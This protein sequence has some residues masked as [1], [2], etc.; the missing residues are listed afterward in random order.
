MPKS[1][2]VYA[3]LLCRVV[4][5]AHRIEHLVHELRQLDVNRALP[6]CNPVL[7]GLAEQVA[8]SFQDAAPKRQKESIGPV[9]P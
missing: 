9:S 4:F 5:V 3:L 7:S 8:L 2:F 6:M 1:S